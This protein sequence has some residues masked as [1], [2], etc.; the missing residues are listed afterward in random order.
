M[1]LLYKKEE[2][3]PV[4]SFYVKR[5][6]EPVLDINWHFHEEYEIIYIIKGNGVRLVGDNISNF[7]SGEL[8]LVGPNMPH[9][10]RTTK[11]VS[12]VDR[13]IIKFG[14]S[15]NGIDLFGLPEFSSIQALL[16]NSNTGI[17]FRPDVIQK[18]HSH[19]LEIAAVAGPQ[20][21]I[22]L[23]QILTILSNNMDYER[24]SSPYVS[25]STQNM[26]EIRLSKVISYIS[27]NFDQEIS[28]DEIADI[29]SMTVQ[30]FC[31][32][33][34]KRTNKT[35]IQFLNEYRIGK[36]C[37]LLIENKIPIGQIWSELGFNSSTNFNRVF[38]RLYGCTPLDF[39]KKYF[40]GEENV[41]LTHRE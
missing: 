37:V 13:I 38:K 16:K 39:R 15:P 30:S 40:K 36:A 41:I 14:E 6:K 18:V 17:S 8:V 3:E 4:N 1:K 28:L 33:F 12:L 32:Y 24:L 19:F 23:L 7:Q 26:G 11:N 35:F 27:E 21:W 10:W 20:K 31:R 25:V 9:L 29:A 22:H 5:V 34:K 2:I